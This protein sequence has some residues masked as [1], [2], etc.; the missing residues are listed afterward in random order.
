M[1]IFKRF[2]WLKNDE[3][4][5]WMIPSKSGAVEPEHIHE[6][7][8]FVYILDGEIIHYIN[9]KDYHCHKG[10]FLFINRGENTVSA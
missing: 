8:E 3:L 1:K 9:D 2:E 4:K 7:L 5:I 6:F 10:A